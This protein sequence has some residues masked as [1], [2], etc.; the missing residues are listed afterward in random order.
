MAMNTAIGALVFLL[1]GLVLGIIAFFDVKL[2]K[3]KGKGLAIGTIVLSAV[4]CLVVFGKLPSEETSD[5]GQNPPGSSISSAE[6]TPAVSDLPAR[7]ESGQSTA[8]QPA[9]TEP[10]R[11]ANITGAWLDAEGG[12]L[13]FQQ[14]GSAFILTGTD[15]SGIEMNGRGTINQQIVA[16]D[17]GTAGYDLA[18][19][20]LILSSDGREMRGTLHVPWTGETQNI[21]LRRQ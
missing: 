5:A 7:T 15:E 19:A 8:S 2:N 4:L 9:V 3:V 10:A 17:I 13:H 21:I 20:R 16:F 11:A 6:P 14:D 1:A 18:K 12:L